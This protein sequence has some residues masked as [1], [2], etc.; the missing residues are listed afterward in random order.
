MGFDDWLVSAGHGTL[1]ND[2][3][4]ALTNAEAAAD[5]FPAFEQATPEQFHA[6][7]DT[8]RVLTTLLKTNLFGSAS[9]LNLRLPA[10]AASDTD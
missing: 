7:Y 3:L 2:I 1:S 9:P 6:L 5:A 4:T 10:S 8:V